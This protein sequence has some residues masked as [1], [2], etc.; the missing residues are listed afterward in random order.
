MLPDNKPLP[1]PMLTVIYVLKWHPLAR[2]IWILH[3]V[4]YY[5]VIDFG[6]I[7][8]FVYIYP[9]SITWL[10]M[11]W[12][13]LLWQHVITTC[14]NDYYHM[15][16]CVNHLPNRNLCIETVG[17]RITAEKGWGSCKISNQV[18]VKYFWNATPP[19]RYLV[20]NVMGI[21]NGFWAIENPCY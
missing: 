10:C 4:N 13:L 21:F 19:G 2:M 1:G 14:T 8:K 7:Y 11:P 20:V 12:Y 3:L 5:L 17:L 16:S 15:T 9:I 6:Y 18:S